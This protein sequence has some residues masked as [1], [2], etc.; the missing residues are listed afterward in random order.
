MTSSRAGVLIFIG[1]F[2]F[3][4]VGCSQFIQTTI[5]DLTQWG[6]EKVFVDPFPGLLAYP[7]YFVSLAGLLVIDPIF[8]VYEVIAGR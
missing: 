8:F 3:A 5:V 4:G 2:L 6:D 7:F 1:L